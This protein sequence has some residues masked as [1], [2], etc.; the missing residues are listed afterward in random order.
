MP[1][2]RKPSS[3]LPYSPKTQGGGGGGGG[4]GGYPGF[5]SLQ[6][7]TSEAAVSADTHAF[8]RLPT[9]GFGFCGE[10]APGPWRAGPQALG[11]RAPSPLET[12]PTGPWGLDP[13]TLTDF[14]QAKF[15]TSCCVSNS[16]VRVSKRYHNPQSADLGGRWMVSEGGAVQF[17][18]RR[19]GPGPKPASRSRIPKMPRCSSAHEKP[20]LLHRLISCAQSLQ[21][22]LT[23]LLRRNNK[24]QGARSSSLDDP[25]L[26]PLRAGASNPWGRVSKP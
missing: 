5:V 22:S 11:A 4:R 14:L 18:E 1:K 2:A 16:W 15:L 21:P 12:W 26:R 10:K 9:G 19:G 17:H 6:V 25:N 13:A 24:V 3:F 20:G 8:A 23:F 7:P